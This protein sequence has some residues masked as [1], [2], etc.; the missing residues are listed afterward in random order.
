[1]SAAVPRGVA[2][3]P[4]L[5]AALALFLTAVEAST[6]A[7]L[8]M[9]YVPT[10]TD[11][12]A[13]VRGVVDAVPYGDLIRAVHARGA[14]LLVATSWLLV[15]AT[16]LAGGFRAPGRARWVATVL[17]AL[18]A[19]DEAFTGSILPWSR[20]GAAS[21]QVAA[22]TVGTIPAIGG[23]LRRAM[24]GGDGRAEVTLVR[25]WGAHAA[26]LPGLASV[27][28]GVA[29]ARRRAPDDD[30]PAMPLYPHFAMRAAAVATATTMALVVLAEFATPGVGA[31]AAATVGATV[32][33]PPWYLG[34][35]DGALRVIPPQVI[36]VPGGGLAVL[37][38]TLLA[39][40]LLALPWIDPR[41]SRWSRGFVLVLALAVLGGTIHARLG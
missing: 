26:L 2:G 1:M 35:V 16:A 34:A 24:L 14:D 28:L 7:L 8:A 33:R 23:W 17:L 32:G 20:D 31:A 39:A 40:A 13:S 19:L 15:L 18:V 37:L 38:G 12:H 36:G 41:G 9:H 6:G 3:A 29:L 11:A 30:V 25:V 22:A 21:A 4:H 5:L 10:L 27:L